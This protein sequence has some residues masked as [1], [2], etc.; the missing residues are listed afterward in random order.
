MYRRLVGVSVVLVLAGAAGATGQQ[1]DPSSEVVAQVGDRVVTLEEVDAAWAQF[2]PAEHVRVEQ[3]LYDGRR[4]ALDQLLAGVLVE[5]AARERGVSGDE[6]VKDQIA[7]RLR[8]VSRADVEA[9]Y[10]ENAT[11]LDGRP[12]T[13][14]EADIR[15]Y[16]GQ[17]AR[18]AARDALVAD[19]RRTGPA[20][21]VTLEAPRYTVD[22][23]AHDP[24]RGAPSAPVTI[25]EFSDYQC[26]FCAQV[27]PT[28]GR[29]RAT[30]GEQIRI[31]W[32][33]FP[34]TAIHPEALKAAEAAH[35]AGEQGQ[36][37][38]YHDR[39]FTSQQALELPSLKEHGVALG[40][41]SDVFDACLEDGRYAQRVR[42][43]MNAGRLLGVGST[44]TIFINGRMIAGAVPYETLSG[45]VEDE[46]ARIE[47]R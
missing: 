21:D 4:N 19:L 40:L 43:G 34:L 10:N 46:L 44:P 39:L 35:C 28:L 3:A 42:D 47:S 14:M 25:V 33:D 27:M 8:P 23:N 22:V 32:K 30:Y 29:L 41:E 16:L 45:A 24:I 6:Y 38:Q 20:I 9:F 13:D 15:D 26:P 1:P 11:Q 36:Y 7:Q 2:D 5:E 31:V 12:L 37:W 18:A 17:Q